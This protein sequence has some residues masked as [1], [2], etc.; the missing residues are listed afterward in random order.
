MGINVLTDSRFDAFDIMKSIKD[1]FPEKLVIAGGPHITLAP[2]D[3]MKT[4]SA[5]DISIFG[6]G[7][8]TVLEIVKNYKKKNF[9]DI[10]G[11][12][13]RKGNEIIKTEQREL[14]MDLDTLPLLDF[15]MLDLSLYK[16]FIQ[17][18]NGNQLTPAI[19]LISSRGCPINCNF[20]SNT[21]LWGATVRLRS[22]DKFVD[23]VE[24]LVKQYGYKYFIFY[25]DTFNIDLERLLRICDLIIE[26]KLDIAWSCAIRVDQ[27]SEEM[28]EKIKNAGCTTVN[29][30]V[31][32][33]NDKIREEVV[34]KKI[35]RE[36]ILKTD[37]L[38]SEAGLRGVASFIVGFPGETKEQALD[39]LAMM[40]QL[41]SETILN[42]V[43]VYPGT[44]LEIQCRKD[45][46]IPSDFSWAKE[47]DM[48]RI[49]DSFPGLYGD[50]PVLTGEMD[51]FE[52]GQILTKW[53]KT[54]KAISIW[55]AG[56]VALKNARSI[57]DFIRIAKI[58]LSY[59]RKA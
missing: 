27:T 43:R 7:E 28:F 46:L 31:E 16:S 17:D 36:Q 51:W 45:G 19:N 52:I 44:R 56:I 12:V 33:G 47:E 3:T 21:R 57:G 8:K 25:D 50:V 14:I 59:F 10:K 53:A 22:A 29:Y 37:K 58:V 41:K 23:E 9:D 1:N 54:S 26:K 4:I 32:S 20:C 34:H 6:E 13:Y 15:G 48:A 18:V 42:V 55:K 11:I 38:L 30:G 39:T 24:N 35:T 49:K 40:K 5:L 2:E